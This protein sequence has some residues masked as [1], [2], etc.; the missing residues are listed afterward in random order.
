MGRSLA[1][2]RAALPE[3]RRRKVEAR[4]TEVLAE[5]EGLQALR[6][7]AG[8][9]QRSV[10]EKLDVKQP[11]VV[12]IEQQSDLYLSTLRRFVEGAGGTLELRVTL[13]DTGPFVLTGLGDFRRQPGKARRK[14]ESTTA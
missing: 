6:K 7:L 11:T 14:L 13:P 5:I 3:A 2:I 12:Q 8:K 10:A 1:D 9:T 4:T